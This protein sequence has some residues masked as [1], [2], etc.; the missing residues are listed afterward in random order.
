MSSNTIANRYAR[1]LADVAIGRGEVNEVKTELEGFAR[2]LGSH[3]E[4][5][6]VLASP[7]VAAER[8][9][10]LLGAILDRMSVRPMTGNF[11]KLLLSN[12]RLTLLDQVLASLAREIDARQG[13]VSAIVTTARPVTD[14]ERAR[15]QSSL[16]VA[17]GKEVRLQF[18]VDPALIGGV[19]TR[20]GSLV[21]DGSVK[22][23][24]G[25]IREQLKRAGAR[26]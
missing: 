23:Q 10:T 6:D 21:Y 12:H 14:D 20:I 7:A 19:V 11:L 13:I 22:S 4:L 3:E 8:K 18:G 1:A 24:L 25:Q 9:Q 17:T 2:M 26:R 16:R 5:R 15:L